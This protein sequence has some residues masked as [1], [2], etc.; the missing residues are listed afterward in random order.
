MIPNKKHVLKKWL[1]CVLS[2]F[3]FF[4]YRVM[5]GALFQVGIMDEFKQIHTFCNSIF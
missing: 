1:L 3:F 5:G 2:N 4:K